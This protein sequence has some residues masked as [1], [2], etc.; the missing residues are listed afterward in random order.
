M[1][2]FDTCQIGVV[3]RAVLLVEAAVAMAMLFVAPT[4]L[5]L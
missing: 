1:L 5:A 2:L 4:P 3:L